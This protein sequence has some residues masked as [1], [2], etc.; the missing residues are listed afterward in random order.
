MTNA[1]WALFMQAGGYDE[2]RWWDTEEARAWQR[3]EG[4]AE[5]TETAVAG[6]SEIRARPF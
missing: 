3:G 1:E 6:E 5:R 2:E 4:T